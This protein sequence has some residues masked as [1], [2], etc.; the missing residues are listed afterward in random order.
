MPNDRLL[1]T[2]VQ[3]ISLVMIVS[4]C[5]SPMARRVVFLACAIR[6]RALGYTPTVH[7]QRMNYDTA[8]LL[9]QRITADCLEMVS[10]LPHSLA[11]SRQDPG[12]TWL[13]YCFW[14]AIKV[15]AFALQLTCLL[16]GSLE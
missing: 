15:I 7:V 2:I 4:A 10:S 8:V 9:T 12:F 5:C 14:L 1:S 11:K 6:P 16:S 3:S 13:A